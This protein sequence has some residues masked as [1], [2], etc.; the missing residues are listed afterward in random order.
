M[1]LRHRPTP[2]TTDRP[3]P[4]RATARATDA[5]GRSYDPRVFAVQRTGALV[6]AAVILVFGV[7]G[8]AGGLDFFSTDG[9]PILGLSSNGLL[10]TV[11]VVTAAVLVLAAMRSP[12]TASTL[13]MVVGV[14]FLVS[15][16]ASLA[17]LR[18]EANLL[19]FEIENVFFAE[20]TG[21]VL[22]LLGAY[23]RVSGNL[24]P[25]SPYARP[26]PGSDDADGPESYPSTPAEF[27]AERA[28]REAEIAV[29]EHR[30]TDDQRRRVEAMAQVHTRGDRR[31][32]WM[33]FG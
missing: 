30:A 3:D 16:L 13:M 5:H 20:I 22:L 8:F 1:Q 31:R 28:M 15:G 33:Q 23:G 19:A 6:V 10:S 4:A 21:L 11:S 24:P 7:L 12:R 29:V 32:V 9:E 18:T 2:R 17:V 26:R 25:D 27:A 14:L